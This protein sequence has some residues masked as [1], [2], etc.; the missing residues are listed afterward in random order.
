MTTHRTGFA[1]GVP[2]I[3]LDHGAPVPGGLVLQLAYKLAPADISDGFGKARMLHHVLDRQALTAD[4]LVLTDQLGGELVLVVSSSIGNARMDPGD[5]A[6][7]L[8]AVLRALF[9]AGMPPLGL[10]QLLLITGKIAGIVEGLASRGDNHRLEPQVD[11]DVVGRLGQG[12]IS[13]STSRETK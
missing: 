3:N 10:R 1:G 2:P 13:F 8:L 7:R 5:F 12:G 11:P 9:L 6:P 4:R